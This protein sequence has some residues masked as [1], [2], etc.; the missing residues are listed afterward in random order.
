[1][2]LNVTNPNSP[3][4]WEPLLQILDL[5][6]NT[7]AF[8]NNMLGP[9]FIGFS[10]GRCDVISLG[11]NLSCLPTH[12]CFLSM[13]IATLNNMLYPFIPSPINSKAKRVSVK[14]L[15]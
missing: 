13:T 5:F 4:H 8:I 9:Q 14:C 11:H 3:L 2:G 10:Y 6:V 1:M 12:A 15:L 7:I